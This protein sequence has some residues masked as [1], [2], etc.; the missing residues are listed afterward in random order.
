MT[1][2]TLRTLGRSGLAVSPL[3]LGTMTFGNALW[4]SPDDVSQSIFYA[5]VERGGNFIDT[6]DVYSG[7]RSEE[8]VGRFVAERSL[9]DRIVMAT[10]YGFNFDTGGQANEGPNPLAG[11][12]G[13]KNLFRAIDGSLKR[14]GTDYVDL[15]WMHVWDGLTPTEEIVGAMSDLVRA[16]KIRYYGL[17]DVPAWF[18]TRVATLAQ[19]HGLPAPIALQMFYSLVERSVEREHIPAAS[20]LGMS[21]VPWSPLAYGLLTG[22]YAREDPKKAESRLSGPNPFGESLFTEANWRAVEA[23]RD[24]AKELG[25]PPSRV[26]LAWLRGKPGVGPI[27]LG[28]RTT[29]QLAENLGALDVELSADVVTRLDAATGFDPGLYVLSTPGSAMASGAMFAGAKVLGLA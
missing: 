25:L 6:A 16:G 20:A 13:R 17:S 8:L 24:V 7:G 18:A 28:V 22:K 12:S 10:K 26:A 1:L 11:G 21:L 3:A 4:G 14:L 9:R 27:L 29:D 5:Y 2:S 19:A 23:L 15:Y